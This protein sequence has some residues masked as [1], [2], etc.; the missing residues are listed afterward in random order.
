MKTAVLLM[1]IMFFMPLQQ[2]DAAQ[3]LKKTSDLI[4]GPEISNN[5][6]VFKLGGNVKHVQHAKYLSHTMK[7]PDD[8]G[9]TTARTRVTGFAYTCPGY[10]TTRIYS[11]LKGTQLIGY[12][13]VYVS[14]GDVK[15]SLCESITVPSGTKEPTE[16]EPSPPVSVTPSP[17]KGTHPV[18]E[19][20]KVEITT[21]PTTIKPKKVEDVPQTKPPT[22]QQ[23]CEAIGSKNLVYAQIPLV[24]GK[25]YENG[26]ACCPVAYKADVHESEKTANLHKIMYV[27]DARSDMF[28]NVTIPHYVE[29]NVPITPNEGWG[30]ATLAVGHTI[31]DTYCPEGLVYNSSTNSCDEQVEEVVGDLGGWPAALSDYSGDVSDES[32]FGVV[33]DEEPRRRWWQPLRAYAAEPRR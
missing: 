13:Q 30:C 31:S 25:D 24:T 10:Y 22:F 26:S 27:Q 17:P 32:V 3:V 28:V 11:D 29:N 19:V 33:S 4:T 14:T 15:N 9:V 2:A 20:E 6:V 8:I 16:A 1:A 18:P 23:T 21:K 12:I 5:R 7:R